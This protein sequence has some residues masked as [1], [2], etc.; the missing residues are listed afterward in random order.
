MKKLIRKARRTV[1]IYDTVCDIYP[2]KS[3]DVNGFNAVT[4][5]LKLSFGYGS[6]QDMNTLK[7]DLSPEA[8]DEI[9]NYLLKKYKNK[10]S[11]RL[12]YDAW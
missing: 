5:T 1:E 3:K 2:E 11:D 8:A 6:D 10:I 12:T 4:S 9:Y 7:L